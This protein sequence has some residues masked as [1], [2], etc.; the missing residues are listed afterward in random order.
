M[1]K[2]DLGVVVTTLIIVTIS[3]SLAFFAARIVGNPKDI[4]LVAKNVEIT[5]TD[6]SSIA[7]ETISPGW[8]NVKSFTI[9]NNSKEDFNYNILLKGL[10]NTF[11]SINTLQYKITS[12]T[13]YNMD[14]YLNIVKTENSKDVVL[15][16]DVVIP[17]GSKQT[18]QVEFK[19]ISIDEDQSSDM[20]KRL[21]GTLAIEESTGKP[22]IYD[23][24]LS[25][26]PT[27]KTRTDFSHPYF[28]KNINTLFKAQENNTDVYYF[29]GGA[30]NNWV[31]FGKWQ[32]DRKEVYGYDSSLSLGKKY[33]SLYECQNATEYNNG[34]EEKIIANKGAPMYWKIMRT[35]ENS[36]IKL[37]YFGTSIITTEG[38]IGLDVYSN[39]SEVDPMWVGYMYGTSGS[40]VNN[41]TNENSSTIKT[42]LENWFSTNIFNY[43]NYIDNNGIF[44][45]DRD[46]ASNQNY[47]I[48]DWMYHAAYERLE[49]KKNPTYN[50][51]NISDQFSQKNSNKGNKTLNYAVGLMTADEIIYAGGKD[52]N[53]EDSLKPYLWYY[54]NSSFES[55][56]NTKS[57]W[58]MTPYSGQP[59][60]YGNG[61]GLYGV[62]G[63]T[64]YGRLG[65]PTQTNYNLMAVRPVINIKGNNIWKSGDGSSSNPYEIVTE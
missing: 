48:Y 2:I 16:Y 65:Q 37:L 24:L 22:K 8:N 15:A 61:A 59:T 41:R 53:A 63:G 55:S 12:D 44:C 7:D 62:A 20:G 47:I 23:K 39:K 58:T 9:T 38:Y 43:Q 4:N 14:N 60:F 56:T 19:Y 64:E 26:N 25:D 10:V 49:K 6:T 5:F 29:A 33:T 11:E 50:C 32:E 30:L 3:C 57:W 54:A 40:L 36:G 1:K 34:C 21:G 13:G 51:N 52:S 45:N 46:L 17:K 31:K 18:Y 28:D 42:Y 27:I 35:T